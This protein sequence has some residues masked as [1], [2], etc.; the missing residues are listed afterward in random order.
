MRDS[1]D[2]E[3]HGIV[4]PIIPRLSYSALIELSEAQTPG[5]MN[6]TMVRED[7]PRAANYYNEGND[8]SAANEGK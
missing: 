6:W 4:L 2:A 5:N 1:N 3:A 8:T 7:D